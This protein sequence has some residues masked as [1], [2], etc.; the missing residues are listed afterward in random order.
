LVRQERRAHKAARVTSKK[1]PDIGL[2]IRSYKVA[3]GELNGATDRAAG[4]IMT[5]LWR[6]SRLVLLPVLTSLLAAPGPARS[7]DQVAPPGNEAQ[8]ACRPSDFR[9]AVDV[10]HTV[11]VPGAISA[12][13]TTEYSFNLR[14]GESIKQ[15]LVKAG[16]DKAELLITGA[17]PPL[18]LLERAMHADKLHA[19]LFLSIHH[20]SVPDNL[21]QTWNYEGHEYHY[22][23]SYPGYALFVSY[24][25]PDRAG[26]LMFGHMLG[27]ALQA[28]GL[29]Y[30]P[31]YILPLMRHRR[32]ELV[33]EAAGVYR[34]DQLVVLRMTRMP[35]VLL[36]A[37]SIVN[38]REELALADPERVAVESAAVV[39]AVE[40][41]CAAR[42]KARVA[43][44]LPARRPVARG[45]PVRG[46][47]FAR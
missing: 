4:D 30:T 27:E 39:A 2:I 13:G 42:A 28:R 17:A 33:D 3:S 5:G 35:A 22:N 34:Y 31:H 14:L 11:A 41:F 21:L 6:C 36:E 8:A 46:A 29:G 7:Q 25:N 10:G 26:S 44:R 23:D 47:R 43:K 16:F 24:D 19:D 12:R 38:R 1:K 20:D 40:D 45:G 37:G 9:V 15:S 32:R 18:G